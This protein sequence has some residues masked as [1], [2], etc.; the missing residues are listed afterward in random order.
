MTAVTGPQGARP[1]RGAS[2][3]L[4]AAVDGPLGSQPLI[5]VYVPYTNA[6]DSLLTS[7]VVDQGRRMVIGVRSEQDAMSLA[8]S[9]RTAI[10]ALDPALAVSHV[11]TI[12]QLERDRS[13]PQR[14]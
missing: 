5:H 2:G 4:D 6:P 10:A 3:V 8:A 12:D 14:F 7:R 13:A 11:Q 1:W 9:A